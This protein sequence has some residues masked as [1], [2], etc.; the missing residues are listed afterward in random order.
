VIYLSIYRSKKAK[1]KKKAGILENS[2][3]T[4]T[5]SVRDEMM[6]N[7]PKEQTEAMKPK[8]EDMTGSYCT[9]RVAACKNLDLSKAC[10]CSM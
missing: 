9:K 3:E 5:P 1:E 2:I 4:R 8:L 6:R 10:V 7:T